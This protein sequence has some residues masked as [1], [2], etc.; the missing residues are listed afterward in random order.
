MTIG[1][2]LG[3]APIAALPL[4]GDEALATLTASLAVTE[5]SDVAAITAAV[6]V[7][8]A[9]A[10]TD[11]P[12]VVAVTIQVAAAGDGPVGVVRSDWKPSAAVIKRFRDYQR[13][14][15]AAQSKD[16]AEREAAEL[17][18]LE[19][20]ERA[21]EDIAHPERALALAEAVLDVAPEAIVLAEAGV[22][23]VIDWSVFAGDLDAI[24]GL[25]GIIEGRAEAARAQAL[26]EQAIAFRAA[27][28]DDI[29]F[30]L[31]AA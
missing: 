4:A 10:V 9:L 26:I 3:G 24:R 23:P 30:L 15:E 18:I 29:E 12:D 22:L 21:Y 5:G 28:E 13:Q 31:L 11:E 25:L 16:K 7:S 14:L 19:S 27:D 2:S 1:S 20:I 6:T 17:R 8:A